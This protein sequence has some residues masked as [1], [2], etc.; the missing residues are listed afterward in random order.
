MQP[1]DAASGIHPPC[2][3]CGVGEFNG[4]SMKRL[5]GKSGPV[6][7]IDGDLTAMTCGRIDPRTK[8]RILRVTFDIT[9]V[10]RP[11]KRRIRGT[12][13]FKRSV[14]RTDAEIRINRGFLYIA[15]GLRSCA[16]SCLVSTV[17]SLFFFDLHCLSV[18]LFLAPTICQL[19]RPLSP[20]HNI[21][22]FFLKIVIRKCSKNFGGWKIFLLKSLFN[23][24]NLFSSKKENMSSNT[25]IDLNTNDKY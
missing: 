4:I 3:R 2:H 23:D 15:L 7:G 12:G 5:G 9:A 25:K 22:F 11:V 20:G 10:A 16:V 1:A 19:V 18:C 14:Y 21:L 24:N 6:Q 13:R 8:W 17:V